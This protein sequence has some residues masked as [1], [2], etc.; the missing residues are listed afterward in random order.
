MSPD[1]EE[2]EIAIADD[3]DDALYMAQDAADEIFE[4]DKSDEDKLAE[5]QMLNVRDD[6]EGYMVSD[7]ELE[8]YI[9]S[10]IDQLGIR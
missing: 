7:E 1:G 8:K 3:L 4:S 5:L 9:W 10:L 6:G 2:Y